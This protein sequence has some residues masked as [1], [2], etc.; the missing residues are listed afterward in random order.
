M[1][2]RESVTITARRG[3]LYRGHLYRRGDR[4]L[5]RPEDAERLTHGR[6]PVAALMETQDPVLFDIRNAT[7]E[8]LEAEAQRRGI[9]VTGTGK[10][11]N[12]LVSDLR[13]AL[14]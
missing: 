2:R 13:A 1:N 9:V 3:I 12:V 11:G 8:Q 6:N 4:I 5:V 7:R 14:R 10:D